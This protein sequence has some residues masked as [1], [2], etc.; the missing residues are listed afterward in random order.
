MD[1]RKI[2][3]SALCSPILYSLMKFDLLK[4]DPLEASN[5]NILT[6]L[7]NEMTPNFLDKIECFENHFNYRHDVIQYFSMFDYRTE[8]DMV[9]PFFTTI[10][11]QIWNSGKIPLITW[12]PSTSNVEKTPPDICR[13]IFTGMFDSYL[14]RCCTSVL[15][16]LSNAAPSPIFGKAKIFIRFAHEMNIHYRLY[17][18]T[19]DF[20]RMW[21]YVYRFFKDRGLN[22]DQVIFIFSP[23]C[24][25][26]KSR[27]FEE[28]FPGDEVVDWTG[29]D[30]YNWGGRGPWNSFAEIFEPPMDRMREISDRPLSICEFGTTAKA[31]TV[32]N[33][34]KKSDW[35]NEAFKWLANRNNLKRYNLKMAI[36]FNI[37]RK[38]DIDSEIY[39]SQLC[40]IANSENNVIQ[41]L[42]KNKNVYFKNLG[43][44]NKNQRVPNNFFYE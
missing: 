31:G 2:I 26:I 39:S 6:G 32:D 5:R 25:D 29:I 10:P 22:K 33:F 14:E 38:N 20:R 18:N 1:R 4:A 11:S 21:R 44:S 12:Y 23:N 9:V 42:D 35:L 30:G 24:V 34:D 7:C 8:P 36:Y 41:D 19:R 17:S 27:P 40:S 15:N 37:S 43:F 13:R 16:Y 28:F 3:K